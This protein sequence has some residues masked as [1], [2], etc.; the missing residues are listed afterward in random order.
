M[1]PKT[2]DK[3]FLKKDLNQSCLLRILIS[4]II[5]SVI[6]DSAHTIHI[7]VRITK[8]FNSG[9]SIGFKNTHPGYNPN[10]SK[11]RVLLNLVF[12]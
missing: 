9:L 6:I 11:P 1:R 10:Y 8:L 3:D 12:L 4:K 2:S 7:I 5:Q